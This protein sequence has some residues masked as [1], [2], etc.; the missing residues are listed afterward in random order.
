MPKLTQIT[1][2]STLIGL[3]LF[4][5]WLPA[6]ARYNEL[7][8]SQTYPSR[9]PTPGPGGDP[10]DPPPGPTDDGGNPGTTA[11]AT[12]LPGVTATPTTLV[13]IAPTPEGGFWP[14]AAS[15]DPSPTFQATATVNV[16]G[17][18]GT[19]YELIGS[20]LFGEVRPIVGRAQFA[21]WWLLA[22]GGG[23]T[24]WVA[25][26]TGTVSG[27]TGLVPIVDSPTINGSTPTP[28]P[29]WA[30][31]ANPSCTVTPTA[32]ATATAMAAT[33]TASPT[34]SPMKT[35]VPPTAVADTATPKPSATPTPTGAPVAEATIT[36]TIPL[37]ESEQ[38]Q[39]GVDWL[40]VGGVG[41][42]LMGVL[43]SVARRRL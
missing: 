19:D 26:F 36:P 38:P 22:L 32:T 37:L 28:G 14:T 24:G 42:V 6:G 9:T 40:L 2:V 12:P 4:L 11:T 17:G 29:T 18:P 39:P 33:A 8:A 27:Y 35:A 20:L 41:L 3:L 30:P 7:G 5:A 16:R 43:F 23:E 1:V 34:P 25:D 10:T 13:T 21:G 15:C 31:T